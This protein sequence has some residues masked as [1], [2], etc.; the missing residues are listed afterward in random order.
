MSLSWE[1]CKARAEAGE[2]LVKEG[3]TAFKGEVRT[4]QYKD[5]TVKLF[6]EDGV[7][8]QVFA[9]PFDLA[10]DYSEV[11]LAIHR[12]GLLDDCHSGRY[13]IL[14]VGLPMWKR[15]YGEYLRVER[16][17]PVFAILNIDLDGFKRALPTMHR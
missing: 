12:S 14:R 17:D 11:F 9:Y 6:V 15:F 5:V 8:T 13:A 7:V 3:K 2:Q 4:F 10:R 1:E 16:E